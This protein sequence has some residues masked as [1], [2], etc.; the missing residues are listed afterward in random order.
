MKL[1]LE[2]CGILVLPEKLKFWNVDLA[3]WVVLIAKMAVRAEWEKVLQCVMRCILVDVMHVWPVTTT[4][5][6]AVVIFIEQGIFQLLWNGLSCHCLF[7]V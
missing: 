5:R 4:N 1:W 6:A 2:D 3:S 7:N